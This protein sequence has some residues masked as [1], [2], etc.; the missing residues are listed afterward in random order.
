[1]EN[2]AE[3][4][5]KHLSRKEFLRMSATA[6]AAVTFGSMINLPFAEAAEGPASD[7]IVNSL[8][9]GAID[10]HI[11]GVL[12]VIKRTLSD[13]DIARSAKAA[14]FK[15]VI[16]KCHVTATTSRAILVQEAVGKDIRVFGGFALNKAEGG[17]NPAGVETELEIGAKEIWLP[18]FWSESHIKLQKAKPADAVRLTDDKGAFRP[19]LY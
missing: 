17:L 3:E 19:E 2:V 10:T 4:N 1:M 16:V 5:K 6:A 13:L 12:H 18:T 14:G 11:H 9:R 7:D 8:L 15:A